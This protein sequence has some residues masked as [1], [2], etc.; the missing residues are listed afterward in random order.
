MEGRAGI[1]SA[2]PT[3]RRWVKQI[4]HRPEFALHLSVEICYFQSP[5]FIRRAS[6]FGGSDLG[7]SSPAPV[8]AVAFSDVASVDDTRKDRAVLADLLGYGEDKENENEG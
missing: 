8:G 6:V 4:V 5:A 3:F 1:C 7:G 2:F